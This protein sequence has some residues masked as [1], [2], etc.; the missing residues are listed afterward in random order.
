[1]TTPWE[2]PEHNICTPIPWRTRRTV[3]GDA[4]SVAGVCS[5]RI[6]GT[7]S[8]SESIKVFVPVF[9]VKKRSSGQIL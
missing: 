4:L 9:G 1:M 5:G 3:Y 8:L 6:T 7:D 2:G